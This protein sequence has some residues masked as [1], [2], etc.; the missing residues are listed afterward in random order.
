MT[1]S[2]LPDFTARMRVRRHRARGRG[3]RPLLM[4]LALLV[5]V[6][7][8]AWVI[9]FSSAFD[10]TAVE[11]RGAKLVTAAQVRARAGVSI[12]VPLAVVDTGQVA[13]R[14]AGLTAVSHAEVSRQWPHTV[15]VTVTERTPVYQRAVAGRYQWVDSQGVIFHETS[16]PS[17]RLPLVTTAGVDNLLLADVATVV[18]SMP[19]ALLDQVGSIDAAT[20]DSI[21]LTLK[22]GRRR[23]VWGSADSSV[24]KSQ[25]ALALLHVR[26]S[27]YN[28]SSPANPTTR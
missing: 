13:R 5:V 2:H 26:A 23:I 4:A 11:V 10:V 3:R 28:V 18:T 16:S 1:D 14:V 9:R 24:L 25:V 12:G 27:V 17:S 21:V 7:F 8:L 15:V 22:D 6:G 19:A 20:R